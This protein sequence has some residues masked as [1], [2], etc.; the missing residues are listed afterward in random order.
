MTPFAL[1]RWG[2]KIHEYLTVVTVQSNRSHGTPWALRCKCAGSERDDN[3]F[4]V[5]SAV[6]NAGV[7]SGWAVTPECGAITLFSGTVR[8]H[9]DGEMMS[10][11]DL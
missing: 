5:T 6:L 11:P 7:P 9:A 3:W 10:S 4:D 1:V 2:N 8:D